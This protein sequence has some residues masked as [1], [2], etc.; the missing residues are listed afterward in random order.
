MGKNI[1]RVILE[2][3]GTVGEEHYK[4]DYLKNIISGEENY[5][6]ISLTNNKSNVWENQKS[7]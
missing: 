1:R 6:H 4:Y 2:I 7:F 5:I 3:V